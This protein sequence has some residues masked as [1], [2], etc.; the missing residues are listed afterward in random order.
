MGLTLGSIGG[1]DPVERLMRQVINAS[2]SGNPPERPPSP[3]QVAYVLH[4]LADHTALTG[5]ITYT[6]SDNYAVNVGR[7]LH[8]YGDTIEFA[9]SKA[10]ETA[11]D[12]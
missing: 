7:W 12:V 2:W 5:A 10:G 1:N 3:Q 11:S 6:G 4:A 9:I 8:A